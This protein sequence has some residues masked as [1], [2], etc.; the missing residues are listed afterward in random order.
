MLI[1]IRNDGWNQWT[2]TV[3]FYFTVIIIFESFAKIIFFLQGLLDC[4]INLLC[5]YLIQFAIYLAEVWE[6]ELHNSPQINNLYNNSGVA[7]VCHGEVVDS[8]VG[9][10]CSMSMQVPD[11]QVR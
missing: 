6:D 3:C 10:F 8:F 11:Q 1:V 5:T 9:L 7:E 4:F 2:M